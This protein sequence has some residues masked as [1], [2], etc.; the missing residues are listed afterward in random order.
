MHELE[1]RLLAKGPARQTKTAQVLLSQVLCDVRDEEIKL[2]KSAREPPADW[3]GEG[4]EE[5]L[6][7][8]RAKR[9]TPTA[10]IAT[11]HLFCNCVLNVPLVRLPIELW[12]AK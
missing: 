1:R 4:P 6:V 10:A 7:E 11:A 2:G 8:K 5:T 3:F 12:R 9:K